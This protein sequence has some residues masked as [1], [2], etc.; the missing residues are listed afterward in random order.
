M[1]VGKKDMDLTQQKR[2]FS[3]SNLYIVNNVGA[4]S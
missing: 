1:L 3:S 2:V 4:F